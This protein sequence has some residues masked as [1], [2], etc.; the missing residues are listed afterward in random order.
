MKKHVPILASFSLL[1]TIFY[2]LFVV[3]WPWFHQGPFTDKNLFNPWIQGTLTNQ[4]GSELYVMFFGSLIYIFCSWLLIR[5]IQKLRIFSNRLVQILCFLPSFYIISQIRA[6]FLKPA[7]QF[8]ENIAIFVC[9][10]LF[11][12]LSYV[13][14]KKVG[15]T[16]WRW[17]LLGLFVLCSFFVI[18]SLAPPRV[19]DYSFY[20]G[21]SLKLLQGERLGTFYMQYNVIGLLLFVQMI[22]LKLRLHQMELV[23]AGVLI[24]WFV[25]YYFLSK[26]F[27][28]DKFLVFLFMVSLFVIR[29][30]AVMFDPIY[31]PQVGPL[32]LDLWVPLLLV[33]SI[34]GLKSPMSAWTVGL[35]YVFDNF[36]GFLYLG[37]YTLALIFLVM[38]RF[39]RSSSSRMT[40]KK[41]IILFLP[42]ILAVFFNLYFFGG[43]LSPSSRLYKDVALDFLPIAIH[44]IFWFFVFLM[45]ICFYFRRSLFVFALLLVQL[46][47]FYGRSHDHNVLNISG[48]LLFI[49]FLGLDG[50]KN[51]LNKKKTYLVAAGFI[52]I[53]AFLFGAT[54]VGKFERA[55]DRI[56]R[57][58]MYD[59]SSIDR[60]I[61]SSPNYIDPSSK[62]IVLS[63]IDSY[64]NYRY[65]LPQI[66][67]FSPF[68]AHVYVDETAEYIRNQ[69]TSG[70]HVVLWEQEIIDSIPLYNEVPALKKNGEQLYIK[71]SGMMY[72]LV[73]VKQ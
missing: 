10:P 60:D 48:I 30:G 53:C 16:K 56:H 37:V 45:P 49:I 35:M 29:F 69:M 18:L 58:V 43:L 12:F 73:L 5:N 36:F 2:S 57:G 54:I 23:M 66:G 72:E 3:F 33:I 13:L 21:P 9:V 59:E 67:Y 68:Y 41:I 19:Y 40:L 42:L 38:S 71:K 1:F 39:Y 26:R 32:R 62:T 14:F 46:I 7:P 15:K 6:F 55:I 4:E 50:A 11:L 24:G 65:K 63:K 27:F 47:Y 44:S 20:I 64:I 51:W 70:Y 52:T 22:L 28:K 31:I 61:D 34:F 25:L 17:Y 8:L